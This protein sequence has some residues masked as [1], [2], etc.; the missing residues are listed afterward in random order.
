M[1]TPRTG[2]R[3]VLALSAAAV[4]AL[5]LPLASPVAAVA[6]EPAQPSKLSAR[7]SS[8]AQ[9]ALAGIR[10]APHGE[11]AQ[12]RLSDVKITP[13]SVAEPKA[14][15]RGPGLSYATVV[16][17][18]A[19]TPTS[20]WQVSY[21][22]F[23]PAA[24]AAFQRA[25]DLWAGTITSSVPIKVLASYEPLPPNVL[26]AAGPENLYGGT[27][28]GNGNSFYPSA[29]A[30]SLVGTDLGKQ[31]EG[32][33]GE[34]SYD[35]VAYFSSDFPGFNYGTGTPSDTQ[36]DFTTVVLH[37]LG[38]GLGFLGSADYYPTGTNPSVPGPATAYLGYDAN[39][40]NAE[41]MD[42]FNPQGRFV[43]GFPDSNDANDVPLQY[44]RF[45]EDLAGTDTLTQPNNSTQM[46]AALTNESLYWSGARGVQGAGGERP[47][48]YAPATYEEGSSYSHLDEA[49]YGAGDVNS[50]M[51]PAVSA[52]EKILD[53]GPITL[54]ILADLG[55]NVPLPLR[56]NPVVPS[57]LLD[58]DTGLGMPGGRAATVGA[59]QFLDLQLPTTGAAAQ[60]QAVTLNITAVG[61]GSLTDVRV[62]PTPRSGTAV[63]VVSNLNLR[64][65]ETRA[66]AVT[67]RIGAN[68]R[69]RLRNT[70]GGIR[71]KADVAGYHV[72][73][74]AATTSGFEPLAVPVRVL[75]TDPGV[76]FIAPDAPIGAG[77]FRD[78][79]VTEANGVP[80]TAT[81]VV[82]TVTATKATARTDIR[83]YPTPA[84]GSAVPA[85]SS[86]N[87]VPGA[88]VP[89]LVVA[90]VGAGGRVRL[91]NSAGNVD[92]RADLVGYY[93]TDGGQFFHAL[94]PRRFL[95]STRTGTADGQFVDLRV[96]GNV[97]VPT[98]AV[99]AAINV[100]GLGVSKPTDFRVYPRPA[101]GTSVPS[102]SVLNLVPRQTAADLVY[103]P[104]G[105]GGVVRFRN[106]LGGFRVIADVGG[107]FGPA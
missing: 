7:A 53:P 59:G 18:V 49:S 24:Q 27:G 3:S 78:L 52:G 51:T 100:T 45:T 79:K 29:L 99:A 12:L 88:N 105:S 14:L 17:A 33:Y 15:R 84:S 91:R 86:L 89:N 46:A 47:R 73:S 5:L 75:S 50:L 30:D 77:R 6:A 60:A 85:S 31:F 80:A 2:R 8:V 93:T 74:T 63:P 10:Q 54:G 98:R 16:P 20:T 83:V 102:T 21:Q 101:N 65:G 68:N 32:Y 72:A 35:I 39:D 44:D 25:V 22:G 106:A 36:V 9:G 11:L 76:G 62:Y 70:A 43:P 87:V 19:Q 103:T 28:L 67:V 66:N 57:R 34:P 95:D 64:P 56:Y 1:I 97:S 71:L 104:F 4:T 55:W 23:T 58:S 69:V 82:L 42:D 41:T 92:L 37:E 13:T 90:K 38:H 81:A 40:R 107:W 96:G 61:G 94:S 48:L 26:G